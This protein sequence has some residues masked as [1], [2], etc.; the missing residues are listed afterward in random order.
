[1]ENLGKLWE[2]QQVRLKLRR[3]EEQLAKNPEVIE[4]KKAKKDILAAEDVLA[5]EEQR[6]KE[7]ERQLKSK[8]QKLADL[9]A[10]GLNLLKRLYGNDAKG[11]KELSG[12]QQQ[13]NLYQKEKNQ[14]EEDILSLT[15]QQEKLREKTKAERERL[16]KAIH[17]YKK[18]LQV[19]QE[20]KQHLE[21]ER[22]ILKAEC[23]RLEME[24]PPATMK[25]FQEMEP[26]YGGLVVSK[27][28]GSRCSA[29]R[30]QV[31]AW[32]IRD[33]RKGEGLVNCESCGRL[34]YWEKPQE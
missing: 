31:A 29:C 13:I 32:L 27:L 23:A 12:L 9:T 2:W 3:L 8:E 14:A 1:M 21:D 18:K 17:Q 20:S 34:L 24:I 11:H 16:N 28:E 5:G 26:R 4:F 30:V 33:L 19:F 22:S 25:L 15:D 6:L 7:M 10:K